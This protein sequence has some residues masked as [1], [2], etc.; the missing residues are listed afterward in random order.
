M[1]ELR[2][3]GRNAATTYFAMFSM[4]TIR[5]EGLNT[6]TVVMRPDLILSGQRTDL[7]KVK[8]ID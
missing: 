5:I 2:H 1:G 7:P 8:K 4:R 6:K 3:V